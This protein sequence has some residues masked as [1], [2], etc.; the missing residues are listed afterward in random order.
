M[1]SRLKPAGTRET[2]VTA[3]DSHVT[4]VGH[5]ISLF[6]IFSLRELK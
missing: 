6:I 1:T 5:F 2:S 3:R 4:C